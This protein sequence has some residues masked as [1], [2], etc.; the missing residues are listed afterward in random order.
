MSTLESDADP[1]DF[2]AVPDP[3][4]TGPEDALADGWRRWRQAL[5]RLP[6]TGFDERRTAARIARTL[7]LLG[8]EVHRGIG[9]T[10][11]VGSLRVGGGTGA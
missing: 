9:G 10:G 1:D 4:A 7:E 3:D 2:P 6:E 5:H 8:L 11:V